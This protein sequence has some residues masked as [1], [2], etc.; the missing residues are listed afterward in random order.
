MTKPNI[1]PPEYIL[2]DGAV[3][4]LE[5]LRNHSPEAA[6]L[7]ELELQAAYLMGSIQAV[8]A[9]TYGPG[10]DH[11][12]RH[13]VHRGKEIREMQRTVTERIKKC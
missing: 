13:A 11:V 2:H 1:F 10:L 8:M 5:L 4:L 9:A 12:S 7:L 6:E 3:I